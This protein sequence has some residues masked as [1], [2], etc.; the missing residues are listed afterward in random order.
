MDSDL[1][2]EKLLDCKCRPFFSASWWKFMVEK[3]HREKL[4]QWISPDPGA[5]LTFPQGR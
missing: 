1:H 3:S 4:V 5:S 2:S